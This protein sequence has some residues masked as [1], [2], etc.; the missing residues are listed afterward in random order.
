A[1]AWHY[2]KTMLAD[3]KTLVFAVIVPL[4][5]AIIVASVGLSQ[6]PRLGWQVSLV[7][8]GSILFGAVPYLYY[9]WRYKSQR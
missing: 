8:T 5:S 2:R 3:A 7:S 9:R 4:V 6:L 1:C